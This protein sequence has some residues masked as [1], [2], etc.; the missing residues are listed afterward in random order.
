MMGKGVTKK[1]SFLYGLMVYMVS[2]VKMNN[3]HIYISTPG[4]WALR[5]ALPIVDVGDGCVDISTYCVR[6][7]VS[8]AG[9]AGY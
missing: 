3:L 6:V 1:I 4:R 9:W 8:A 7:S 2:N 5:L